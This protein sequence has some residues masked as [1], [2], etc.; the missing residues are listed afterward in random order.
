MIVGVFEQCGQNNAPL[1]CTVM[2]RD[3]LQFYPPLPPTRA[4]LSQNSVCVDKS[5]HGRTMHCSRVILTKGV[6]GHCLTVEV[7]SH[8]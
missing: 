1:S 7:P 8:G 6:G 5:G 3:L 4:T 2:Y